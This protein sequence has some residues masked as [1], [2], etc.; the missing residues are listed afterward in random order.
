MKRSII[1]RISWQPANEQTAGRTDGQFVFV[2]LFLFVC[3]LLLL[4]LVLLLLP[5]VWPQEQ[6]FSGSQTARALQTY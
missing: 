6:L 2:F 3:V 5:L 1:V 4:L